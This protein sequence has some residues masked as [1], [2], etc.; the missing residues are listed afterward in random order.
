VKTLRNVVEA[1][2]GQARIFEAVIASVVVFLAFSTASYLIYASESILAQEAVDLN[3][4]SYNVL[5][6]IVES[7]VIE[8]T[9]EEDL[10]NGV[11]HLKIV[12]QGLLPAGVYFNLT[13]YNCT[14]SLTQPYSGSLNIGNA[15]TGVFAESE[16]VISTSTMYTSKRGNIYYL[17][18]KLT[19]V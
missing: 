17:V 8:E 1:C 13:I 2:K 16:E 15:P 3:R 19:R 11:S 10:Q 6:R 12:V 9:V 4:L 5:H 7:G 18:L 14:G